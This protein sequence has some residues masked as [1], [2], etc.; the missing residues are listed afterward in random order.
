MAASSSSTKPKLPKYSLAEI[1]SATNNFSKD[2]EIGKGGFGKVYK[3]FIEK[4]KRH[5]AVKRRDHKSKQ[6]QQEFDKEIETLP[7]IRHHNII[8]LFGYCDDQDEMILVYEYVSNNTLKHHLKLSTS[9]LTWHLRITILIG[10]AQGLHHLHDCTPGRSIINRD[11]KT[12]NILLTD[13]FVPKVSDF[14]L[15]KH[16]DFDKSHVSTVLK[17]TFGYIDLDYALSHKLTRKSDVLAFGVIVLEVLSGK[18]ALDEN[19]AEG[20]ELLSDWAFTR[21]P[22]EIV[23]PNVTGNISEDSLNICFELAKRCLNR[24]RTQRPSMSE[25]LFELQSALRCL[26]LPTFTGS[27]QE[28]HINQVGSISLLE[29]DFEEEEEDE[30]IHVPSIS[31]DELRFMTE[32]FQRNHLIANGSRE[33]TVF[34]GVLRGNVQVAIKWNNIKLPDQAFLEQVFIQSCLNHENVVKLLGFC[35]DDDSQI[36]VSEFAARGSLHDILHGRQHQNGSYL[37]AGQ[38]LGWSQRIKIAVD[39]AEGVCY[40]HDKQLIHHNIKSSNVLLFNDETA[41]MTDLHLSSPYTCNDPH[42]GRPT[43][44][45]Y[46]PPEFQR[47]KSSH[48]GDVYSFGIVL[49]ELLKG[50]NPFDPAFPMGDNLSIWANPIK[51][52]GVRMILDPGLMQP[53]PLMA[54]L[55]MA[56]VAASCLAYEASAR[57]T[58]DMVLRD[59]RAASWETTVYNQKHQPRATRRPI[60]R[61]AARF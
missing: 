49:L 35:V 28:D 6:G 9:S 46:H 22:R 40:I 53:Y 27:T 42:V 44:A 16:V 48:E 37:V 33:S 11:V 1:L 30:Q 55:K 57:P 56:T 39:V 54:I 5:V 58:M 17:G 20:E 26:H 36:F 59:L 23:D 13:D 19:R 45:H 41:K 50:R 31:I 12:S 52:N 32:N 43:C 2:L 3:G 7:Q 51:E 61:E 25:V 15:A 10:I 8:S 18:L 47:E 60:G 4:E 21:K 14:G 38:A 34:Y 24:D 29:E